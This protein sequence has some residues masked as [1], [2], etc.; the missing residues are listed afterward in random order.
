MGSLPV[1]RCVYEGDTTRAPKIVELSVRA[2][3][4]IEN[5][6]NMIAA[7]FDCDP[8]SIR[9]SLEGKEIEL[10][11]FRKRI[12]FSTKSFKV[13]DSK[14]LEY[15]LLTED[16]GSFYV[17]P[18]GS[19]YKIVFRNPFTVNAKAVIRIDGHQ[20]GSYF[21]N[22]DADQEWTIERHC[23]LPKKFLF[24]R[25]ALVKKVEA[26]IEKKMKG[27]SITEEEQRSLLY[28]P[29]GSGIESGRDLNG[30]VSLQFT[31]EKFSGTHCYDDVKVA[32]IISDYL[33][34]LRSTISVMINTACM[35]IFVKTLTGKT[36]T[37]AVKARDSIENVKDKI[38]DREGI[39]SDNQR[40]IFAGKQLEDGRTLSDYNI[41][42]EST[43]H[44]VLR[45]RGNYI[46]IYIYVCVYI[47]VCVC[48]YIYIYIYIYI[49][50]C[51]CV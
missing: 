41:Q 36:I 25:T 29:S 9:A 44:Q 4:T 28:T 37:L 23:D 12:S 5:L 13:V 26:I 30:V 20:V 19:E 33:I 14:G 10:Y 11:H 40:L 49:Y 31:P 39:P 48:V 17:L 43:L 18:H 15:P 35:Y 3:D 2:D 47:C 38:Q 42:K 8:V 46:S 32:A 51:V 24:L 34:G 1:V 21:L 16:S 6:Y 50:M 45:L 7:A 27:L 22:S